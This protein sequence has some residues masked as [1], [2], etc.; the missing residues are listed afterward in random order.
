MTLKITD[1]RTAA[2]APLRLSLPPGAA[3]EGPHEVK[4]E[5]MRWASALEQCDAVNRCPV[6]DLAARQAAAYGN[7][8]GMFESLWLGAKSSVEDAV[9]SRVEKHVQEFIKDSFKTPFMPDGLRQ[10]C[11]STADRTRDLH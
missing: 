2:A 11:A 8:P 10:R 4:A 9:V 3:P 1:P 7:E 6:W 5:L